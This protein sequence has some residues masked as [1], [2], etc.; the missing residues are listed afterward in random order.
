MATF[1]LLMKGRE[2]NRRFLES[3]VRINLIS[4]DSPDDLEA[5]NL[6]AMGSSLGLAIDKFTLRQVSESQSCS[7]DLGSIM[8]GTLKNS[9]FNK[10]SLV[11]DMVLQSGLRA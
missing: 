9:N 3:P 1:S 6:L 8:K 7:K 10:C 5:N 4:I 2:D 11:P